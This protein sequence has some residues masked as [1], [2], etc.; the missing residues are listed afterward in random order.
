V[1]LGC[2]LSDTV[3]RGVEGVVR[4][5]T[6]HD[7]EAE[8]NAGAHLG[9]SGLLSLDPSPWGGAIYIQGESSILS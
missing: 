3:H 4:A 9:T 5:P 2:A 8:A 6:L 7:Q 1:D